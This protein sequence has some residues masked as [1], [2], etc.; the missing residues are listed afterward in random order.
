MNFVVGLLKA[1]EKFDS[2]WVV[3]DR[4]TKSAHFILVRIDNNA[5]QLGYPFHIHVLEEIA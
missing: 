3:V 2:I 5:E 1:L 4:L